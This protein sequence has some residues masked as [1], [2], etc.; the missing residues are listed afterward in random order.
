MCK[1]TPA[2]VP[3]VKSVSEQLVLFKVGNN[4]ELSVLTDWWWRKY[5]FQ[6]VNFPAVD[7]IHIISHLLGFFGTQSNSKGHKTFLRKKSV[8]GK[9]LETIRIWTKECCP[10]KFLVLFP[11][12]C[13]VSHSWAFIPLCRISC[14]QVNL[15]S[16]SLKSHYS[17]S[18]LSTVCPHGLEKLDWFGGDMVEWKYW[19]LLWFAFLAEPSEFR[20][21]VM[22]VIVLR[23]WSG[24]GFSYWFID[25][26]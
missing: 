26:C 20:R 7:K 23:V 22:K 16:L 12:C 24:N 13:H 5:L 8:V 17:P 3:S 4:E 21:R 25:A 9:L 6:F 18:V 15:L 10:Q 19:S 1:P 2:I 11:C 14:C